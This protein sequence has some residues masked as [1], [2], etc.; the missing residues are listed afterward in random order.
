MV[1]LLIFFCSFLLVQEVFSQDLCG[2]DQEQ[3]LLDNAIGVGGRFYQAQNFIPTGSGRIESVDI[4]VTNS[5]LPNLFDFEIQTVDEN[6]FP[7]G[8]VLAVIR[9]IPLEPSV[10]E[11]MITID[12]SCLL[13]DV[14]ADQSYSLVMK[15]PNTQ[16][17]TIGWYYANQSF[18]PSTS[19]TSFNF[20]E[21][22]SAYQEDFAYRINLCK[23]N[24]IF[25]F[26][27]NGQTT[28]FIYFGSD[29]DG[30]MT[31][32]VTN[33]NPSG[34]NASDR[35]LS[36]MKPEEALSWAGAYAQTEGI[37]AVQG[38]LICVDVNFDHIGNLAI[39]LEQSSTGGEDWIRVVPNTKENEWEQ[40]CFDFRLSSIE[41][42]KQPA[43][44]NMYDQ[45]TIFPDFGQNGG[46]TSVT[47]YLDNMTINQGGESCTN[48]VTFQVNMN[49]FEGG[50]TS[51]S[52]ISNFN[53][54][55]PD[56][57]PMTDEDGDG[58]WETTVS[59][60]TGTY[61][62]K[63][64]VDNGAV[65]EVFDGTESCIEAITDTQGN[66][67]FQ[68]LFDVTKSEILEPVCWNTCYTCINSITCG[69]DQEQADFEGSF[70]IGMAEFE[71][72]NF[73]P[74]TS[75]NLKDIVIWIS[76]SGTD[77]YFLEAEIHT[78]NE[79]LTPSGNILGT[80]RAE[81][82]P[83]NA[84][85]PLN[86]DF[87]CVS[88]FLEKGKTYTLVLKSPDTPMNT[89]RWH[90]SW[91]N[92]F[93]TNS[94]TSY[95]SGET[96]ELY[97]ETFTYS[98]NICQNAFIANFEINGISPEFNYFN[99]IL[100]GETAAT[101]PNPNISGINLTDK[102]LSFVKPAGAQTTAGANAMAY[103][104]DAN[105]GT[106]VCIDVLY[107]HIGNLAIKLQN[108]PSGGEDWLLTVPNTKMNEWEQLC[109]DLKQPS[110]EGNKQVAAGHIYDQLS[111]FPDYGIPGT[112]SDQVYYFDNMLLSSEGLGCTYKTSFSINM[113]NY[114]GEFHT[115][116]VAGNFNQWSATLHPMEDED[117]DGIWETNV[118]LEPGDHYYIFSVDNGSHMEVFEGSEVCAV[119]TEDGQGNEIFSR[120]LTIGESDQ[121]LETVC[122]ESCGSC[123]EPVSCVLDQEQLAVDN[124]KGFGGRF[125][126]SQVFIPN[127]SG[128]IQSVDIWV[129]NSSTPNDIQLEIRALD[130]DLKP[131]GEVLATS[132]IIS[133]P[134]SVGPYQV[135]ADF[136][137]FSPNVK[138]GLSY[139]L[140][141]KA[142]NAFENVLGWY[143]S[144]ESIFPSNSHSSEDFGET[145]GD[146]TLE[147]FAYSLTIC[148]EAVIF[149][150]EPEGRSVN[151]TYFGSE[152]DGQKTET[153]LNPNPTGE[154]M[155]E[156]VLS[157]AKPS[158][159]QT[160][161]GA[162][163]TAENIDAVNGNYIC[164]DVNFDH[165]GNLGVKL[166]QSSTG[167]EDWLM[168]IPNTK[169]GEWEQ[170]CFDLRLPSI[171]GS[172]KAAKGNIYNQLVIFP[173]F[174]N[175]GGSITTTYY[176][177]NMNISS[178]GENCL[179]E[180]NFKINM[181]D[182]SGNFE[183]V[184]LSG[185]FNNWS[186]SSHPLSDA[187]ENG[188]WETTLNLENGVYEY[189]YSLDDGNEQEQF[190]GSESCVVVSED[191]MG[192]TMVNRST[193][194]LG[195]VDLPVY[196]WNSCMENC[197]A[198]TV[199]A[200]KDQLLSIFPTITDDKLIVNY[201]KGPIDGVLTVTTIDG[202]QKEVF[203]LSDDTSKQVIN[204]Q[205]LQSGMY[206][207]SARMP[208]GIVSKRFFK[209]K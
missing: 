196:C 140:V 186:A 2:V 160:W 144:D 178:R 84:A 112:I 10:T 179:N 128:Y 12:F 116:Y 11:K 8:N 175:P 17:N 61:Q 40:L 30:Q 107:D 164:V 126:Q 132:D 87:S 88:P 89:L 37:D 202:Y 6:F 117:N 62:Y 48:E 157:Y 208:E 151:F 131:S 15:S 139:A 120:H 83:G 189:K 99:S 162:F 47:Y 28:D 21:N 183:S 106:K 68:R 26:E 33:P 38:N 188:V 34:I 27:E 80:V 55:S 124:L 101:I 123:V 64:S 114:P 165:I 46:D 118:Q 204:V 180:V 206:I 147:D 100:E 49:K 171:E 82:Y 172:K 135:T 96:W 50:F 29:L 138:K 109:F 58:I 181:N 7:S 119:A 72:Q 173:D 69:I 52:V 94:L 66:T 54:W 136:S 36:Y 19:L 185:D 74:N 95:D 32:V 154:N 31:E 1:R 44:G 167:G 129:F 184:Y 51:V 91:T 39:K 67:H 168:T 20:G 43:K 209:F 105:D 81:V 14:K 133:L 194:I 35:V 18:F 146:A 60:R 23:D 163:A 75:G 115:V 53:S 41:G 78:V 156:T 205:H 85:S 79:D 71:G 145:W 104:I 59:L 42:S 5:T 143:H 108:S 170:L 137:C 65:E 92:F 24:K 4:W 56:S 130:Q 190:E 174:N 158:G 70:G 150:F 76:N 90:A 13:P 161:A 121:V 16:E 192:N 111:I 152:L 57:N 176:L 134:P 199:E 197:T 149:D 207:I 159:A 187:D 182:Y 22:W 195:P 125:F 102:V 203:M 97:T 63:F 141:L 198:S 25:D 166:E 45:L 113:V 122:W 93:G 127:T 3:T 110:E 200:D 73:I 191:G 103:G 177:D 193:V 169:V 155:S 98:L 77:S 86:L 142:A 148:S 153:V 201:Q 9:D